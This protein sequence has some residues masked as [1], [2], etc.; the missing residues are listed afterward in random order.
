MDGWMDGV[1][2]CLPFKLNV[3]LPVDAFSFSFLFQAVVIV[4]ITSAL[5]HINWINSKC[6]WVVENLIVYSDRLTG[7][8]FLQCDSQWTWTL[9]YS[10]CTDRWKLITD[11]SPS[12]FLFLPLLFLCISCHFFF[13]LLRLQRYADA[14]QALREVLKVDSTCT[15]ARQ[16]LIRV[17]VSQLMV[18]NGLC[19][20]V[21]L[22]TEDAAV[23]C[24][25]L[26]FVSRSMAFLRS[27]AQKL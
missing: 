14:A 27:R 21:G 25:L 15:E 7:W 12:F 23:G 8:L 17:Q 22:I 9:I 26:C 13:F 11:L 24:N 16:E 20:K 4:L 2:S 3:L 5:P 10:C 1:T 19:R 18:C 6:H